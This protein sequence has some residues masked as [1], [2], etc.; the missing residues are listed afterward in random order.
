M[1]VFLVLALTDAVAPQLGEKVKAL[2]PTNHLVLAPGRW[3]VRSEGVSKTV[4]D[5][6]EI[7]PGKFGHAIVFGVSGYFGWALPTVWEW[8]GANSGHQ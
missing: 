7:T 1:A 6:L 2:Y 5:A 3:L 4:S 8:M